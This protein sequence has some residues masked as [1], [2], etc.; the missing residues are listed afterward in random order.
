MSKKTNL[1]DFSFSSI[2]TDKKGNEKIAIVTRK[3]VRVSEQ[4]FV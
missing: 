3:K 1:T 2:N 4:N